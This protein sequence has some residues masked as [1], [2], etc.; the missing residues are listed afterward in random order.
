MRFVNYPHL[1]LL[2]HSQAFEVTVALKFFLRSEH[3]QHRYKSASGVSSRASTEDVCY[4]VFFFFFSFSRMTTMGRRSYAHI[5]SLF[6]NWICFLIAEEVP[7]LK[8]EQQGSFPSWTN[9][10]QCINVVS[11]QMLE[12]IKCEFF[13]LNYPNSPH[14]D[15]DFRNGLSNGGLAAPPSFPLLRD[16][17]EQRLTISHFCR[18]LDHS[19]LLLN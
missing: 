1:I 4:S 5:T 11:N 6:D 14:P 16:Y 8:I 18:G 15:T 10:T 12:K 3:T 7:L 19:H 17:S 13:R 2:T 9:C